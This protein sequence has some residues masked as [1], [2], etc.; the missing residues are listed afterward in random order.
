MLVSLVVSLQGSH[1]SFS[2][3]PMS[4]MHAFSMML[5][6]VDFLNIFVYPYFGE[7]TKGDL[8]LFPVTT[9][10]THSHPHVPDS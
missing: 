3:V 10:G 7:S 4:V 6:E 5:G 9:Y 1:L 8:L 2:S